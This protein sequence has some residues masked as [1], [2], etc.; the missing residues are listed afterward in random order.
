MPMWLCVQIILQG[1]AY[2][3][4]PLQSILPIHGR[5]PNI[6][7]HT[8]SITKDI[9]IVYEDIFDKFIGHPIFAFLCTMLKFAITEWMSGIWQSTKLDKNTNRKLYQNY[10]DNLAHFKKTF[11]NDDLLLKMGKTL[12]THVQCI[13]LFFVII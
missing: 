13:F 7:A 4:A 6:T 8:L 9:G 1:P 2:S 10:M 12:L 3:V 5:S 11:A